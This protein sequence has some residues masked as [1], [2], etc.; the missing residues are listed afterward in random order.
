[1][2]YNHESSTR[3]KKRK[4]RFS[5]SE[6][7]RLLDEVKKHRRIVVGTCSVKHGLKHDA[8]GFRA[9]SSTKDTYILVSRILSFVMINSV[10]E[11]KKKKWFIRI[12][13]HCHKTAA[14]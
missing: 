10:D 12:Q 11:P 8:L 14:F 5:Y 1:M 7:H 13:T 2:Y 4:A 3:F 9:G 6:V